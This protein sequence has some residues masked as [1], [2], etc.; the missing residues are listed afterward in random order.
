MVWTHYERGGAARVVLARD[1][2]R[3]IQLLESEVSMLT[4]MI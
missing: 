3:G 4:K 1:Y 2:K